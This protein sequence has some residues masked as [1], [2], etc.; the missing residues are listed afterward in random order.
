MNA[1][2]KIANTLAEIAAD[3]IELK[4]ALDTERDSAYYWHKRYEEKDAECKEL[5]LTSEQILEQLTK[6][7]DKLKAT[8]ETVAKQEAYIKELE[9]GAQS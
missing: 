7:K 4:K 1:L 5:T 6:M 8:E 3:N 2:D 9:K